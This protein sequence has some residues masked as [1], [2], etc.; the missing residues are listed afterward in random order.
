MSS[1][2]R[3]RWP[4]FVAAGILVVIVGAAL[5]IPALIDLE[6][7]RARIETALG[8]A[9]GWEVELGEMDFSVLQGLALTVNPVR[10]QAPDGTCDTPQ[11]ES[12][13][14]TDCDDTDNTVYPM[15]PEL[16]DG[17]LNT[18][19]GTMLVTEVDDL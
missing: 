6:R 18:C 1:S 8:D 13:V 7:H 16:C 10:L 5:A 9:T 4:W 12:T 3:R 11:G 14:A 15:A 17:Q 2:G 19:G